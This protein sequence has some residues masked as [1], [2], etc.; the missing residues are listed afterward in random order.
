M[1][2]QETLGCFFLYFIYLFS[3]LK[4]FVFIY[5]NKNDM[6]FGEEGFGEGVV[7]DEDGLD[8]EKLLKRV[9]IGDYFC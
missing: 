8:E 1:Q 4:C 6:I 5:K 3:K 2:Y 7:V 9:N